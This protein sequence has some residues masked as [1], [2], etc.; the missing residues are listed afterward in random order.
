[1]RSRVAGVRRRDRHGRGL[2]GPL[3]PPQA[4]VSRTRAERFADLVDDE[5]RRLAGRWG[6]EL[7]R[8]EFTVE[9]VPAI[10]PSFDGP[11]PLGQTLPGAGDRPV[12]IAVYRRPVE[13]RAADEAEL[14]HLV[15][16]L[17][18]EEVADLLGLSPESVDP[19]YDSPDD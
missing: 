15:R 14:A 6:R 11:V 16:D 18:V 1:M 13:A 4:P 9:E 19:S 7:A 2:R 10:D 17:L 5:V 3:T 8:V 12:R